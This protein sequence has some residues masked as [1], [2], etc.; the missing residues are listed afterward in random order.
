MGWG[1]SFGGVED[2][3]S[4]RGGGD[5]S[6]WGANGGS[7]RG[8]M[9]GWLCYTIKGMMYVRIWRTGGY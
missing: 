1:G 7:I 5:G 3:G 9:E 6:F 2:G 4:L 8:A